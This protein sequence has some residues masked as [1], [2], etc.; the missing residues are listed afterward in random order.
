MEYVDGL[1]MCLYVRGNPLLYSDPYGLTWRQWC[2][3]AIGT[4][5]FTVVVVGPLLIHGGFIAAS[6]GRTL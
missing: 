1:N 5:G 4:A 3:A 2:D 6:T